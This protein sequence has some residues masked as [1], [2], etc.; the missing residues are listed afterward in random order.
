[1]AQFGN[2]GRDARHAVGGG[3]FKAEGDVG[4]AQF[5][6]ARAP[7]HCGIDAAQPALEAFLRQDVDE[8]VTL[9]ETLAAMSRVVGA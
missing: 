9:E 1:M 7:G 6:Q 3:F 8:R 5:A 2:G 4:A